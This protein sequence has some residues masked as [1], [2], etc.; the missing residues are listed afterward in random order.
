MCVIGELAKAEEQDPRPAA[1]IQDNSFLIEEA[2][3][4][5]PGVIQHI[6]AWR[7]LDNEWFYTLTDEWPVVTQL[8]QL[9]LTVPYSWIDNDGENERG[10]GDLQVNYRYQLSFESARRPAIAPRATLILPTG[11]E[12]KGLGAGSSGFQTNLPV[13]KIVSDRVPD[14]AGAISIPDAA[15]CDGV[16]FTRPSAPCSSAP[17]SPWAWPDS[18][19][20]PSAFATLSWPCPSP[21]GPPSPCPFSAPCSCDSVFSGDVDVPNSRNPTMPASARTAATTADFQ[22]HVMIAAPADILHG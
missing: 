14:A 7:W 10:F 2:Y 21:A 15:S 17:L 6:N 4:Q 1:G 12:K 8:H 20:A 5:E 16:S 9:S 19:P 22:I 13:S 11:D 18:S 3:N